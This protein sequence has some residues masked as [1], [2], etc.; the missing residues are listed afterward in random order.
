[1]HQICFFKFIRHRE[2]QMEYYR[3]IREQEV[4]GYRWESSAAFIYVYTSGKSITGGLS[5][6]KVQAKVPFFHVT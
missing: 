2:N 1:M 3:K 5:K 6:S 4:A